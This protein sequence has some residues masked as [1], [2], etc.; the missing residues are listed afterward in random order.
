MK[1]FV[2]RARIVFA[3]VVPGG[4]VEEPFGC[5]SKPMGSHFGVGAP[6]ILEPTLVGIGMFTHG[7]LGLSQD[8]ISTP[9][10]KNHGILL[11][12][13]SSHPKGVPPKSTPIRCRGDLCTPFSG[14]KGGESSFRKEVGSE[15]QCVVGM[16]DWTAL[17]ATSRKE[18]SRK[19]FGP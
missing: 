10:R 9:P 3:L 1:I 16:L 14:G 12:S 8:R 13:I 6:P 17:F 5:G 7:H 15:R 19:D 18:T 4:M 2:R 11:V